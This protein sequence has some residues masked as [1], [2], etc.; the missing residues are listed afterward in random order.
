MKLKKNIY[1]PNIDFVQKFEN[2]LPSKIKRGSYIRLHFLAYN[3]KRRGGDNFRINQQT[4]ILE[5]KKTTKKYIKFF[6]NFFI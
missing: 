6:G 1:H 2:N 5:K 3:Q 4:V